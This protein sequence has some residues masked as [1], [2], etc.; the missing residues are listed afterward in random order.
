M[1]G[2]LPIITFDRVNK[3]F[4]SNHVLRDVTTMV[5]PGER[6]VVCGPSG[7]GK[8]TLINCVN[9]MQDYESGA[10]VVDGIVVSEREG[11]AHEVRAQVGMVFQQFNLFPHLTIQENCTLGP[12]LCAAS[13]SAL[14]TSAR[15][16]CSNECTF[17]SMPT[18]IPI[19]SPAASSS[20]SR[21]RALCACSRA[22]CCS[23]SRHRRSIPK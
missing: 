19:N 4:G 18:N 14:P 7:S 13:T 10:V 15:R 17:P 3:W 21:L 1:T 9:G 12:R 23:M 11:T 8:S 20:A 2:T 6:I 22:S 5:N 16:P